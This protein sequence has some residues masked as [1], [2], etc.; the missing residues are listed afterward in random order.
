[1]E[2]A[3]TRAYARCSSLLPGYLVS[4]LW[5]FQ[6]RISQLS[7]EP[8]LIRRAP[9]RPLRDFLAKLPER[10]YDSTAALKVR[11]VRQV[12]PGTAVRYN[13]RP[14]ILLETSGVELISKAP[15][16]KYK[17]VFKRFSRA[18]PYLVH[19]GTTSFRFIDGV[20]VAGIYL[21]T[22]GVR[23]FCDHLCAKVDDESLAL[24]H[25]GS[26]QG[27]TRAV[28]R[29]LCGE[30]DAPEGLDGLVFEVKPFMD[31]LVDAESCHEFI[32]RVP[33]Y[34]SDNRRS[35]PY[36]HESLL[37]GALWLERYAEAK[38]HHQNLLDLPTPLD[39]W[40]SFHLAVFERCSHRISALNDGGPVAVREM[41]DRDR[42][43][44]VAAL[45]AEDLC[46]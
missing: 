10:R 25:G 36:W 33:D 45:R 11:R 20:Y 28:H 23:V 34:F 12:G 9:L 13:L 42:C 37:V 41:L 40:R 15:N 1:M 43:H 24:E 22:G 2:G 3:P 5:A 18:M 19:R 21:G 16:P 6:M 32:S 8:W 46:N 7:P 31:H 38:H 17:V 44:R 29:A 30:E 26:I 27:G 35:S 14:R 39:G 4:A